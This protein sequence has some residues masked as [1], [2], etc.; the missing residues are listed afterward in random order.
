MVDDGQEYSDDRRS[1]DEK[2]SRFR[3]QRRSPAWHPTPGFFAKAA[4][5]V[6]GVVFLVG[7]LMQLLGWRF[8]GSSADIKMNTADI[9]ANRAAIA[10]NTTSI[11]TL[12][13][14]M[15]TS[16]TTNLS[17]E[18]DI[19]ELRAALRSMMFMQCAMYSKMYADAPT[20][21]EC[22]RSNTAPQ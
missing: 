3:A 19:V 18:R 8:T 9:A 1:E 11:A 6:A 17:Q 14:A 22:V 15:A 5:S 4:A 21:S 16:V 20:I 12:T 7:L 10:T 13:A 2:G